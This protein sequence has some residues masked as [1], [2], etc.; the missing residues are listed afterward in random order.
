MIR[1]QVQATQAPILLRMSARVWNARYRRNTRDDGHVS[2]SHKI[3]TKTVAHENHF[4]RATDRWKYP[5][6][7][8]QRFQKWRTQESR[9]RLQYSARN[10]NSPSK[11]IVPCAAFAGRRTRQGVENFQK[12]IVGNCNRQD[13]INC[14]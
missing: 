11:K 7:M 14:T 9:A 13:D 1:L 5:C 12:Y 10:S 2:N 4:I 6:V 8:A 3:Q